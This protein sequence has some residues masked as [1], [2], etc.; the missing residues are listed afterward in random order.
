MTQDLLGLQ[1]EKTL[2][3]PAG[4]E[5]DRITFEPSPALPG[6]WEFAT[7][8]EGA[9]RHGDVVTFAP[10]SLERLVD[11]PVFAGPHYRRI[12]LDPDPTAPVRLHAFA[13]RPADS[14]PGPTRSTCTGAWLP[15]RSRCS[16]RVTIATTIS[17]SRSAAS[18]RRSGSSTTNRAKM[19][20]RPDTSSRARR[21]RCATSCRTSWCTPGTASSGARPTC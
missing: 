15:R 3:Y 20:W 12:E 13:D 18:S 8:L 17:C 7:A 6:G 14:K 9:R 21:P 16:A 10:V 19:P 11:S 1:W 5:S 4:H 2:L